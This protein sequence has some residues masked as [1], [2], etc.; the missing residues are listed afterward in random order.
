MYPSSLAFKVH[1]NSCEISLHR[2]LTGHPGGACATSGSAE[3]GLVRASPR[4]D[5]LRRVG[6]PGCKVKECS[7][8]ATTDSA[9]VP[10]GSSATT[11]KAACAGAILVVLYSTASVY[12]PGRRSVSSTIQFVPRVRGS[13]R[14]LG[15][16]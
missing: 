13:V 14:M 6:A 2:I 11:S 7:L 3:S 10:F 12:R 4:S 8:A 5:G 1:N 15:D 16:R 9:R